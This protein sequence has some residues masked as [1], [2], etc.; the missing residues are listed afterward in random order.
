MTAHSRIPPA[1]GTVSPSIRS[2]PGAPRVVAEFPQFRHETITVIALNLDNALL[3]C[4]S[5][6]TE[7]LQPPGECLELYGAERQAVD[8][9]YRLA[10]TTRDLTADADDTRP[11]PRSR[12][13]RAQS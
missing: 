6:P 1:Q 3:H 7:P 9:R 2:T 10:G 8:D 11:A 13:L 4:T 5:R 12:R